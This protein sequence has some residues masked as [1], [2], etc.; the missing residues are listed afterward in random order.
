MLVQ[1]PAQPTLLFMHH[2]PFRSGHI[3]RS[4]QVR[5]HGTTANTAASAAF[6]FVLEL[7]DPERLGIAR[8]P[9]GFALHVWQDGRLVTHD[10]RVDDFHHPWSFR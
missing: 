4:M 1:T 8:E 5:W 2:P 10:C 6:Q 7:R 9:P 3:H